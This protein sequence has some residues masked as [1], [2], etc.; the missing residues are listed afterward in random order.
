MSTATAIQNGQANLN[1]AENTTHHLVWQL[2][3]ARKEW[4]I[5]FDGVSDEDGERRFGRINSL[6]WFMA[7]LAWHEMMNL[8]AFTG[9]MMFPQLH[10][11]A[12]KGN[13][14]TTPKLSEMR[15]LWE[16]IAAAVDERFA[17]LTVDDL[18]GEVNYFGWVYPE[19]LG[20][21]LQRTNN[22]YFYH[23]GEAAAVRQLLDHTGYPEV[24]ADEG[25]MD[26]YP[27]R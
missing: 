7:H 4:A 22:H 13:P 1:G 14:A 20:S 10:E 2:R 3:N 27:E 5:I 21:V 12:G 23:M 16:Q 25:A 26:Y 9:E 11:I 19:N 8:G 15:A 17:T 24:M 6:G 18:L